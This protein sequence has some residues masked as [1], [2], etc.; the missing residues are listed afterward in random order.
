MSVDCGHSRVRDKIVESA[1]GTEH[2]LH[3]CE[4]CSWTIHKHHGTDEE[5]C[6]FC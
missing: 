5:W 2:T 1:I 6:E 4:E 3:I